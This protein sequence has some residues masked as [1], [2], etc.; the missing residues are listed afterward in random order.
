MARRVPMDFKLSG[1]FVFG[2]ET[3]ARVVVHGGGV[4]GTMGYMASSLE[5]VYG[6]RRAGFPG[7]PRRDIRRLDA[8][9]SA[10]F[11]LMTSGRKARHERGRWK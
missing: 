7:S 6:E 11:F 10:I 4:D 5:E 8:L 3:Q 1:A 2:V 9:R